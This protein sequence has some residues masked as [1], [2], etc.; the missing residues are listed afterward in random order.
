VN[1]FDVLGC[2]LPADECLGT[3]WTRAGEG[4]K[5]VS[6]LQVHGKPCKG[7]RGMSLYLFFWR[8]LTFLLV[9]DIHSFCMVVI[10][11]A[12]P[13]AMGAEDALAFGCILAFGCVLA[14]VF[15]Q[16]LVVTSLIFAELLWGGGGEEEQRRG[17]W[18]WR[19]RERDGVWY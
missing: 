5:R 13:G 7:N 15:V 11:V 3:A 16:Q 17:I 8:G 1:T 18:G 2:L 6:P 14:S 19:K 12:F 4:Q 10:D 9:F